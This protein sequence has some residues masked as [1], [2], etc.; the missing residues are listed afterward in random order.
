[1]SYRMFFAKSHQ[2][3]TTIDER[4]IYG[5]FWSGLLITTA[6]FY[7][8]SVVI[9]GW[10]QHFSSQELLNRS[11][12]SSPRRRSR[13]L[14]RN[15]KSLRHMRRLLVMKQPQDGCVSLSKAFCLRET[16]VLRKM[17]KV[18]R[19]EI[20]AEHINLHWKKVWELYQL[21]NQFQE[22]NVKL[23]AVRRK[24]GLSV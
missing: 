4:L 16:P 8:Q 7:F 13:R 15:L 17:R 10:G 22:V 3:F 5:I 14:Q 19:E 2:K 21:C 24:A 6:S 18:F 12:K 1:M 9:S 11:A 20:F 23:I